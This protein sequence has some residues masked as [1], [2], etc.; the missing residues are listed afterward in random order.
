MFSGLFLFGSCIPCI[1]GKIMS[2]VDDTVHLWRNITWRE[3]TG[4]SRSV[5]LR[6]LYPWQL[7]VQCKIHYVKAMTLT[8]E[9]S[10]R[11]GISLLNYEGELSIKHS[12]IFQCFNLLLINLELKYFFRFVL[13][14]ELD[15]LLH[16]ENHEHCWWDVASVQEYYLERKHWTEKKCSTEKFISMAIVCSV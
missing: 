10:R 12:F 15:S 2:T 4:Q 6:N 13:L 8:F 16:G 11:F 7:F 1:M 3:N 9:I 14:W 5:G